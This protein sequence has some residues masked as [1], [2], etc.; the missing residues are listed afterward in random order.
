MGKWLAIAGAVVL[1]LLILMWRELD[2]SSA[3]PVIDKKPEPVAAAPQINLQPV[4]KTAEVAPVVDDDKPKKLDPMGDEFFNKFIELVPAV[5][6]RQAATCY[7]L[8]MLKDR[9][10]KMVLTF[11]VHVHNG[12]VTVRDV[13]VD[14]N[15]IANPGLESCFIQAVSRSGWHDDSL[16]DYD[17][18]DQLVIRPERGLKKYTKE[19]MD[20]VGQPAE[21]EGQ[22]YSVS[23]GYKPRAK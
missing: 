22:D 1:A 16:P 12:D 19:N 8:G 17:W 6:S 15:T 5:L 21:H 9:N 2:T 4:A 20:Y 7:Q 14:R 11:N 3:A 18:P 13:K 23:E 10:Q